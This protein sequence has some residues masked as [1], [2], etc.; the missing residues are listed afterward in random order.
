MTSKNLLPVLALS[1]GLFTAGSAAHFASAWHKSGIEAGGRLLQSQQDLARQQEAQQSVLS[2]DVDEGERV[3][4]AERVVSG[5]MLALKA[6]NVAHG[7]KIGQISFLG[8]G[9]SQ[10]DA[11]VDSLFQPLA[12]SAGMVKTASMSIKGQYQDFASFQRY[13]AAITAIPASL[14]TLSLNGKTFELEMR[15]YAQ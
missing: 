6:A 1:A 9:G 7:I 3:T 11:T 2:M 10:Q 14:R 12:N 15:L 8:A 4:T 13:L 5:A